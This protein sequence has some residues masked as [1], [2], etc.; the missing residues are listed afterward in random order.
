MEDNASSCPRHGNPGTPKK[1]SCSAPSQAPQADGK[2]G[3]AWKGQEQMRPPKGAGTGNAITSG[4]PWPSFR[5]SM[6]SSQTG[7][8]GH[9]TWLP[10]LPAS[11]QWPC[12]SVGSPWKITGG[13]TA[14][15]YQVP[16]GP[17]THR[18]ITAIPTPHRAG[19]PHLQRQDRQGDPHLTATRAAEPAAMPS[20]EG[21]AVWE[22]RQWLLSHRWETWLREGSSSLKVTKPVTEGQEVSLACG[23]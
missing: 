18:M 10:H 6:P 20:P 11:L 9:T 7:K 16:A 5:T 23:T 4:S 19:W 8:S 21:Q 15:P 12:H 13:R 3:K 17:F 1:G 2:H 14:F 22:A